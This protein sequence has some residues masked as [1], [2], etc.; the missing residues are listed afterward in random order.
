MS[1][2]ITLIIDEKLNALLGPDPVLSAQYF[3]SF[4]R[5]TPLQP[6]KRLMLA[7]LDDAVMCILKYAQGRNGREQRLFRQAEHWIMANDEDWPFSFVNVCEAL[8]FDPGYLRSA[9]MRK[10]IMVRNSKVRE[11]RD[12]NKRNGTLSRGILLRQ[13]LGRNRNT[14]RRAFMNKRFTEDN[15]PGGGSSKR[16]HRMNCR[17]CFNE[18]EN[19]FRVYTDVINMIV[20]ASCADDARRLGLPVETWSGE[21]DSAEGI[22]ARK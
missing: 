6:E 19:L 4:R 13:A 15:C 21:V 22:N 20:C 12:P 10:S 9:L 2:E 17:R 18:S 1:Y 16:K 11:L 3:D 14:G 7:V 8:S 5:K